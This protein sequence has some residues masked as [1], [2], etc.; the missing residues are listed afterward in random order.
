MGRLL[1]TADIPKKYWPMLMLIS[2]FNAV[3]GMF[4]MKIYMAIFG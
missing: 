2:I 3:I 4:A 1:G